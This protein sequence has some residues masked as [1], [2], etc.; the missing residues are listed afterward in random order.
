M[1]PDGFSIEQLMN[2]LTA[3]DRD[4]DIVFRRKPNS[5]KAGRNIVTAA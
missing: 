4:A 3:L 1:F 5:R 2:L